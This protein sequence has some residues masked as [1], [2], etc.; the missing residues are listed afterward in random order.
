MK[1]LNLVAKALFVIGLIIVVRGTIFTLRGKSII[2]TPSSFMHSFS[3]W[4]V[5]NYIVIA[6][7]I[8]VII[9]GLIVM[10]YSKKDD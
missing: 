10:Q 2:D 4:T 9:A 8:T 6:I 1:S 7:G 3:T 5:N